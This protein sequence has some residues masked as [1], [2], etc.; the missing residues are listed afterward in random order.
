MQPS[1]RAINSVLEANLCGRSGVDGARGEI[2]KRTSSPNVLSKDRFFFP[3]G[4]LDRHMLKSI[5][6]DG[7]CISCCV[8]RGTETERNRTDVYRRGSA[9]DRVAAYV[10][11]LHPGCFRV[12]SS[13]SA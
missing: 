6:G 5:A 3:F 11:E 1:H 2:T 13:L 8:M 4:A 7:L 10:S 9:S 12:L